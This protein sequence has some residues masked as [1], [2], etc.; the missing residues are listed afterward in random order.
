MESD[1]RDEQM[2][3]L[4]EE[5]G[6][7]GGASSYDPAW[8][9]RVFRHA[10]TAH[11]RGALADAER[12]YLALLAL[13]QDHAEAS[14]MLGV[15]RFQEE[16]LLDA[17]ALIRRSIEQKPSPLALANHAAVLNGLGRSEEALEGLDEALRLNP[18]HPRALLQRAG[19]LADLGRLDEA[20]ITYDQLL[21]VVP[22]FVEGLCRRSAA[23]RGL[24]RFQ[25]AL[26]SCDRALTVDSRSFEAHK[27]RGQVSRHL[28]RH[29]DA[30]AN[31]GRA[32]MALPGD[33]Q[34]LFMQGVAF[35]DLQRLDL[36]L[37]SFNEAV[38]GFPG[39][40]EATFNSAVVLERLGRFEDAL[41]RCERVLATDPNHVKALA[42]RG[43]V[44][45]GLG[46]NA[47]A[48]ASYAKALEIEPAAVEVLCNQANALRR[49]DRREEALQACEQALELDGNCI[50]AWFG[51]SRVL[52]GL[53]R[54]EE[55]LAGF[56]HVLAKTPEDRFAQFHRGNV[57]VA[58]RRHEEAKDAFA[59]AIAIDPDF[60]HA[61]CMRA[62][63]CL[64]L[65]DFRNGWE[66]YEWR[67][68]DEQM[69]G[70][71]RKFAQIQWTG[72]EP[73][74]DKTILLHAEQG[75]GDTLQ[76]CRYV[77]L[78][79]ALGATVV[80]EAPPE[81]KSLLA[82]LPGVDIFVDASRA[83]L[84]PFD[85]HC[86]LM[87]LPLALHTE[88]STIP[89]EVPYLTPDS[90]R[91]S[92]WQT[93]LGISDRPRIGVVWSG[94]PKH[95]ND[96]NRSIPLAD[97]KPLMSDAFEWISAQKVVREGDQ[98]A[99][100]SSPLRHFGDELVDFSDTA[101][102]L[103]AVDCVL[104]VDTSV[105]HLAGALGR[106][107]WL[108]LPHTPDFRWLLDREDSPWYPQA[109]LFRQSE[110]GGWSGVFDRLEVALASLVSTAERSRRAEQ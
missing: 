66:E 18:T 17:E 13:D 35:L 27:E 63:L 42:N 43:N 41:A 61:H 85:I 80:L 109:R 89:R 75:L 37:A 70:G 49:L 95:L 102:L 56:D 16:K 25:D 34:V 54:Y 51:R 90:A 60:V 69:T 36:A 65:A 79:K 53:H 47:E 103:Q 106:P 104:S 21:A 50:P 20:V 7:I 87:S 3:A 86:P 83:P 59:R 24:A 5:Q 33:A 1:T 64:S 4:R 58:L 52:H 72:A 73:L 11:E 45:H 78:V 98:E 105:A 44:L 8:E 108:L 46:R 62:F 32:L 31:F 12:G 100:A 40:A 39:F 57:L 28:G 14:H 10:R 107:L 71:L 19:I 48:V 76:F 29:E 91:V 2:S 9:E 74:A 55:A 68:R 22:T 81:L 82:T 77:P 6:T 96:R 92:K 67:W 84:P 30:L 26:V 99:L 88:L 93:K 110:P 23:L 101:A 38:A 94:N 15:L 97:L